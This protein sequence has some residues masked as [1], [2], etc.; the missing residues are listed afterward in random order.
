ME[1]SLAIFNDADP[2]T[3]E[4]NNL[5]PE[6]ELHHSSNI[7]LLIT[8][9]SLNI[10]SCEHAHDGYEFFVP[11]SVSPDLGAFKIDQIL[12]P[13]RTGLLYPANPDQPHGAEGDFTINRAICLYIQKDYLQHISFTVT[14]V[15]QVH[16]NSEVNQFTSR[17]QRLVNFFAD[18]ARRQ[19]SGYRHLLESTS[20]QIVIELLRHVNSNVKKRMNRRETGTRESILKAIDYLNDHYN[21]KLSNAEL[22][23][24][25]NLSPY[26]FIRLFKK[27][28]GKTPHEYLLNIKIEKAKE[29]L[30][31]TGYSITEICFLCGFTE[32]SHFSKVFKKTTGITPLSYR[33]KFRQ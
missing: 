22:L 23:E 9:H 21:Q 14:G 2:G 17:L 11:Y 20:V 7:D 10:C 28:T 33:K 1:K 18:E 31:Y 25:A 32:H 6:F 12:L 30:A 8:R 5:N 13:P 4:S 15:K 3:S 19:Q 16:F 26:Y 24:I 29:L 27:E